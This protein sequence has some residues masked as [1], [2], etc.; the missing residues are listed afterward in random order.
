MIISMYKYIIRLTYKH[1]YYKNTY[2]M[3]VQVH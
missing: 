2:I 1:V 3:N